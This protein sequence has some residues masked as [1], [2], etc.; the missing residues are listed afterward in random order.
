MAT[1]SALRINTYFK[2]SGHV[3]LAMNVKLNDISVL[4]KIMTEIT[5]NGPLR[6]SNDS[7]KEFK[8]PSSSVIII[9]YAYFDPNASP[10]LGE[11]N[12][13]T[14]TIELGYNNVFPWIE[15]QKHIYSRLCHEYLHYL[16]H[17]SDDSSSKAN[18]KLSE[19]N[20]VL[21]D[22]AKILEARNN[23][24]KM[25]E[26]GVP[27]MTEAMNKRLELLEKVIKNKT[28]QYIAKYARYFY[29]TLET[30]SH[31][32]QAIAELLYPQTKDNLLDMTMI[33][34]ACQDLLN[35]R[36]LNSKLKG[37]HTWDFIKTHTPD[38]VHDE[39]FKWLAKEARRLLATIV[40]S[41]V[42]TN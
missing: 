20:K 9:L 31:A 34:Q 28:P 41:F 7:F 18:I 19:V 39:Y 38:T 29:H 36:Q 35:D 26:A 4:N 8:H 14:K 17:V 6:N 21:D 30:C 11:Y 24:L 12:Y 2:V 23:M 33:H 1:N 40:K 27:P 3:V 15:A 5:A 10:T 16:Q 13:K 42:K 32:G 37:T 22:Y 25:K